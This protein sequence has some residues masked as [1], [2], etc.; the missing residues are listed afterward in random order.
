MVIAPSKGMREVLDEMGIGVPIEVVPNG[1]NLAPFRNV[2]KP[3]DRARF[4]FSPDDVIL[5]YVGR[6]SKEKNIELLLESFEYIAPAIP[7]GRLL[8]VGDGPEREDLTEAVKQNGLEKWVHF[9]GLVPYD[10][11]PSY[12]A[13]ADAFVTASV[14][15][16]HPLTVIE[17]MAAGL[18]VVGID[19]P[20]VGDTVEHEIS[21]LL[22]E[23]ED[24]FSEQLLRIVRDTEGRHRMAKTAAQTADTY[25]IK[26][27]AETILKYYEALV[28]K[29]DAAEAWPER[30]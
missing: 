1:V 3:V 23:T 13:A 15:E 4:G 8:I 29:R 10:E 9:T 25:S 17:A 18:P 6:V 20:G 12:L 30:A 21:G 5:I 7:N 16:V 2:E 14:T 24:D 19:S 28:S 22:A 11:L 26:R 27:N